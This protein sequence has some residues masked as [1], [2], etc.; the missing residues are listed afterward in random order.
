[1]IRFDGK[2]TPPSRFIVKDA[3]DVA[4]EKRLRKPPLV[5][6]LGFGCGH[7]HCLYSGH[8][9]GF[10]WDDSELI[11]ENRMISDANGLQ[12]IWFTTEALDYFPITLSTF[13]LE[14]RLFGGNPM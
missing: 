2:K 13:W 3:S 4:S 7:V 12:R 1:M 8:S 9:R 14:W 10:V 6:S 11:T 5:A